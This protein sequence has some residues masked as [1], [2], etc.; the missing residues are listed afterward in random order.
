[1]AAKKILKGMGKLAR[2]VR[3][4]I[5]LSPEDIV[6]KQSEATRRARSLDRR[7][8][9]REL[10]DVQGLGS[11]VAQGKYAAVRRTKRNWGTLSDGRPVNPERGKK[12]KVK[13]KGKRTK[14]VFTPM[15]SDREL[16]RKRRLRGP[17]RLRKETNPDAL[18]LRR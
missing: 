14:K 5:G 9:A 6:T 3:H 4:K 15:A 7:A 16:Q 8:V 10:R 11:S 12:I 1:M 2:R 18:V 17:V 13:T